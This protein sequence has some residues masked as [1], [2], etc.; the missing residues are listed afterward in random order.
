MEPRQP[1][2]P[3]PINLESGQ[4]S[5][6]VS[7]K[8]FIESD[9]GDGTRREDHYLHGK[10]LVTCIMSLFISLFLMAL[11][12][13][14]VVTLLEKVGSEFNSLDKIGWLATGF[15]LGM[16]VFTAN[17]GKV[18]ILFGRKYTLIVAIVTFEAGS[19]MCA[20]APTMNVLIGGRVLAGI[21]GGG[22]QS[23]V[24]IIIA[25][26]VP[27]ENRPITQALMGCVFALSTV[28]GPLIGGAFTTHVTWRWCFYINLP[29]GG[30]AL[31][32]LLLAFHPPR[33]S[34]DIFP[35]LKVFDYFGT[36]LLAIGIVIFLL[37]LTFGSSTYA[38]NSSAVI[39]CF[40]IG[41]IFFILFCIWNIKF[42]KPESQI[43]PYEVLKV[44]Q[45]FASVVVIT[46][47]FAFYMSSIIYVSLYFQ[48]V[49]G[50]SAWVS[51]VHTLPTI[52][53][54]V[55]AAIGSGIIISK[56]KYVKPFMI[57]GG[58]L[59]PIGCGILSLLN[60]DS[61]SGSKIG[62]LI[63]LGVGSG[64]QIQTSSLSAQL[65]APKIEGATIM[66]TSMLNF[67]RAIGGAVGAALA[68]VVYSVAFNNKYKTKFEQLSQSSSIYNE[69]IHVNV[70]EVT[71]SST[72]LQELSPETQIFVK[73]IIVSAMNNVYY[74][75]VGFS[76]LTLIATLFVSN[77]KV[78]GLSQG[79]SASE[80]GERKLTAEE[81][82]DE[83]D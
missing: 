52:V 28:L 54:V 6:L 63:I 49:C 12:Q 11:D 5:L 32:F 64:L 56:F 14:I 67:G 33:P 37:A 25:E 27:I 71:S 43:F 70:K 74:M 53:P 23:L 61:S 55:V 79:A 16:A 45:V 30:V 62:L 20:L 38:W 40:V 76:G 59:G 29:I 9:A 13:T 72:L 15:F 58:I 50:Y 21:G 68:D 1:V 83:K 7:K 77:K 8:V 19:L 73:Q 57:I 69:L 48:V 35:K 65:A 60:I 4:G 81:N 39:S 80:E 46:G 26:I 42:V 47:M 3:S 36:L 82:E 22:I 51:G 2:E 10:T 18:S 75:A 17:W 78:P 44:Y 24:Y 41:P 31:A 66:A 34:G